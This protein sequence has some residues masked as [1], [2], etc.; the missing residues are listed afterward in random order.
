MISKKSIIYKVICLILAIFMLLGIPSNSF[1]EGTDEVLTA[2]APTMLKSG[3]EFGRVLL[4][5]KSN[6]DA[7]T[8]EI[9]RSEGNKKNYILYDT[10]YFDNPSCVFQD[11][12]VVSGKKYYYK[13]RVVSYMATGIDKKTGLIKH[14]EVKAES[15]FKSFK[16]IRIKSS[17]TKIYSIKALSKRR[18]RIRWKKEEEAT[19]FEIYRSTSPNGDYTKIKTVRATKKKKYKFIDKNLESGMTY[20][21]M[22]RPYAMGITEHE[23]QPYSSVRTATALLDKTTITSTEI[24]GEDSITLNWDPISDAT[25]YK[26]YFKVDG[27]KKYSKVA[28]LKGADKTSYTMTGVA[29]RTK[30]Y[31][32]IMTYKKLEKK[33]LRTVSDPVEAFNSYY[34]YEGETKEQ[35]CMRIFGTTT[36]QG[37]KSASEANAHMATITIRVWDLNASGKKYGKNVSLTVNKAIAPTVKKMF[38]EIYKSKQRIPIHAIGAYSYRGGRTEHNEG[39]AIDINPVENYMIDN[40]VILAGS[41]WNPKK[42]PYSIPLKCD[43]VSIMQKYG[44]SRG[45]WGNRKDYMHFSYFGT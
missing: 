33:V 8:Y 27:A 37:Y 22:V 43:M 13:I 7:S 3:E 1:A 18:I 9:Y 5:W 10:V 44:F 39:L 20:Y 12:D 31:F 6:Y 42:S 28:I 23:Y 45:F 11:F 41:F 35:K 17:K 24:T 2:T 30:I 26:V 32:K 25:G 36:Y 19:G 40:G 14:D 29:D 4:S 15:T 34:A 38:A 16:K 21:Y